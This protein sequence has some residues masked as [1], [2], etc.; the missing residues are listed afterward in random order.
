MSSIG[1][2]VIGGTT[3]HGWASVAHF[4]A[5][6]ALDDYAL[7]AV[8]TSRM[9]SARQSAEDLG[10]SLAFDDHRALVAHPAVN[11]VVVSVKVPFH[12]SLAMAAIDAGK[13][14]LCE[15]PLGRDLAEAVE[16][17]E[18]ARARGV[19]AAVGLQAR[20][21]PV[22]M[23]VR[24]LLAKGYVGRVLSSSVIGSGMHWADRSEPSQTYML[25]A[26]N[27]ATMLSIACGHMLDAFCH[28]LGEFTQLVA[29]AA[30][31]EPHVRVG[32]DG[33][34]RT[35]DVADQIA[36]SGTVGEGVTAAFHYRARPSRGKNFYW[37]INGTEGDLVIEGDT[38]QVQIANLRLR[39]A[40]GRARL[41]DIPVDPALCLAPTGILEGSA[42][43][44]AQAYVQLAR[45]LRTGSRLAPRFEDAVVRHSLL[46]AI[47]RAAV[48]GQRQHL[49]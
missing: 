37:E 36:V 10:I 34:M 7:V 15:W 17:A 6:R 11:L 45:D 13:H 35:K 24:R 12:H 22:V 39:G 19:I 8:A 27:G 1:V 16:L 43:N 18:A 5:L 46:D 41:A 30:I 32:R 47:E 20:F 48:T 29:S 49:P 23:Q 44:V 14:V 21:S 42:R 40:R 9:E 25:D 38:G 31:R 2:G 26:A 3:R 4:P 33:T 28:V